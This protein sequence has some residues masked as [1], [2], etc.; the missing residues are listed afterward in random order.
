VNE[1]KD[2]VIVDTAGR[3]QTHTNL[4]VELEKI[5]RVIGKRIPGAPHESLL[6]LDATTGQNGVSQASHF[7]DIVDCTG[8]V[9]A[10]LDGSAKGG[11]VVS[12]RQKMGIPVKYVGLGE[13]ID[14]LAVFDPDSFV[15]A[16]VSEEV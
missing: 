1:G 3:L 8:L 16:L 2:V 10:K 15:D 14:D 11:V 6:V 5:Y 9:L 12:I 4:M 7:S 13:Q